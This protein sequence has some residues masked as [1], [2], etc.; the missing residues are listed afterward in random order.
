LKSN[1]YNFSLV[2]ENALSD[3]IDTKK[4]KSLISFGTP[5]KYSSRFTLDIFGKFSSCIIFLNQKT[6]FAK[7]EN[8]FGTGLNNFK[9]VPFEGK[10]IEM[11]SGEGS[12][13]LTRASN[14]VIINKLPEVTYN[15][16]FFPDEKKFRPMLSISNSL[17]SKAVYQF[18]TGGINKIIVNFSSFWKL[19][20]NDDG[21]NFGKFAL[22]LLDQT[23]LSESPERIK[24]NTQKS[25]YYSG[26]KIIFS[27][28]IFDENMRALENASAEVFVN[29]NHL[30]TK[31]SYDR[32]EY[33]A[34][35]FISEPGIYSAQI[36]LIETGNKITGKV[37]NFKIIENDMETQTI[38]A[39]TAFIKSFTGARDG[40]IIPLS[41]AGKFINENSN[42]K[43]TVKSVS[44]INLTRNIYFFLMLILAFLIELAYRKYKD[45]P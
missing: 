17:K 44:T 40:M 20:F 33:L 32:K 27:G 15:T 30:E 28:K 7:I 4:Y 8:Y 23:A 24:I 25:E 6:D 37:V 16:T 1:G 2:Y 10:L 21:D 22:N 13:L 45:L 5:T 19:L 3:T 14:P 39:D 26:E 38:G 36:R 11:P 18:K 34:E 43:Q 42:I 31:F 35:M 41:N 9:Y 29:E 12:F